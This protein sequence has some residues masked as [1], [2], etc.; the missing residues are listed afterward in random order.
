MRSRFC[1]PE[2]PE[3]RQPA[4][5]LMAA[6][7]AAALAPRPQA[8]WPHP[9]TV[10]VC[11]Q[12]LDIP[13]RQP[14]ARA[15]GFPAFPM[16]VVGSGCAQNLRR[17]P[18]PTCRPQLAALSGTHSVVICYCWDGQPERV[19]KTADRQGLSRNLG[20][21]VA[22]GRDYPDQSAANR[23]KGSSENGPWHGPGLHPLQL[24]QS[25]SLDGRRGT[26]MFRGAP[27]TLAT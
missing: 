17:R 12:R 22:S 8:R 1:H 11:G 20:A 6:G 26:R 18:P 19:G 9:S 24:P 7:R 25:V 23:Q 5:A 4:W 15:S 10:A 21:P 16:G 2:G 13:R 3:P 27:K 14:L